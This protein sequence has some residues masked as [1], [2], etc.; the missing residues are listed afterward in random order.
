MSIWRRFCFK[1]KQLIYSVS[2]V[3][4]YNCVTWN[5]V[6]AN[7]WLTLTLWGA[8]SS[9]WTPPIWFIK[10]TVLWKVKKGGRV[11]SGKFV[12][13][14]G[15]VSSRYCTRHSKVAMFDL[16]DSSECLTSELKGCC[17][18]APL[19]RIAVFLFI[20]QSYK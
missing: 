5:Q 16:I 1:W 13:E 10:G 6:H 7:V 19:K 17:I 18:P 4:I 15:S 2:Y 20:I 3:N 9:L 11:G 14:N 12:L 8:P